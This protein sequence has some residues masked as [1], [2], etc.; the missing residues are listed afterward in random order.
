MDVEDSLAIGDGASWIWNL[1]SE[2]FYA[3]HQLVDWFHATEHLAEAARSPYG[4]GTSKN[5]TWYRR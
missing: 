5:R 2:H 3:R 1:V 4:E